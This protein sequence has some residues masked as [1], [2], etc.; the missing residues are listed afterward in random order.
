MSFYGAGLESLSK[1]SA[2]TVAQHADE[3]NIAS[4]PISSFPVS[5]FPFLLLDRPEGEGLDDFRT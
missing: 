4:F 5:N 1:G 2:L 3:R